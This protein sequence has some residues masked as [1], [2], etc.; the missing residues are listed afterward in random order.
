MSGWDSVGGAIEDIFEHSGFPMVGPA[1][2]L[3]VGPA[4]HWAMGSLFKDAPPPAAPPVPPGPPP[5]GMPGAPGGITDMLLPPPPAPAPSSPTPPPPPPPAAGGPPAPPPQGAGK[6][7]EAGAADAAAAGA[8]VEQLA[9]LDKQAAAALASIHDAGQAGRAAL[10]NIQKDINDKITQL[11]PRL[12]T[13][14]GQ[15]ELRD[16]LKTKLAD[17]KQILDQHIS[18]AEDQA[19]KTH[20]LTSQYAGVGKPGDKSGGNGEGGKGGSEGGK[21]GADPSPPDPSTAP[22]STAPAAA[23]PAGTPMTPGMMMPGAGMIPGFGGGGMP[24][25]GGGGMPG[26]GGGGGDP[27]SGLMGGGGL[28]HDTDPKFR[29]PDLPGGPNDKPGKPETQQHGEQPGDQKGA[30]QPAGSAG[31]PE[32]HGAE[33]AGGGGQVGHGTGTDVKLPDGTTTA[34]RTDQGA[35]AV[36][37]ALNGATVADAYKQA[38]VELPP[39]GTPVTDPVPPT[40]LKAG[41]VG[42]WKDHMVM[43]LGNGKVLVSGQPQPQDSLSSGPDFLGWIDPTKGHTAPASAPQPA[44]SEPPAQS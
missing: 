33:N 25:F 29:D 6:A 12:N 41:D 36:R 24:G 38:G 28:P 43:A 20:D 13:P 19:R 17:A 34:A 8:T 37:A 35:A 7:A 32:D 11:G 2:G 14:Q 26:F 15:A 18:D 23:A 9:A 31:G 10:D 5:P 4:M 1:A 39:A 42:M 30:T 21:G 3:P 44:P 16:F 27:L 22:A 40:Q